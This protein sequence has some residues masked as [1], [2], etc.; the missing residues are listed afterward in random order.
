M[1]IYVLMPAFN[2]ASKIGDLLEQ[3]PT[4]IDGYRVEAIVIDDGSDDGT[5]DVVRAVGKTVIEQPENM[6]KGAALCRGNE[7]L[8]G[9]PVDAV[10][11]M[12]SDGQHLP[13]TIPDLVRPVLRGDV[14]LCVGS[15]YMSSDNRHK[16]PFNR[17]LVRRA[18]IAA[19]KRATGFS[20]TDPFSGFRCFSPRAFQALR[21]Q[22]CGY[23]SELE[24]CFSTAEAGLSYL[25]IPIP[26]IYGPDTS[27]MG[28]RHGAVK[29]RMI[30]VSGYAR[31]IVRETLATSPKPQVTVG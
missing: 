8:Q 5:A 10:V 26:R 7:E 21:L 31:T 30:V 6:G 29:G 23:E 9:L 18:T 4:E 19:M 20:M 13:A 12:D 28:Y 2:E 22:G 25:E 24:S 1:A 16:A 27:K 14:D 17:R 3:L 11:W 15:R